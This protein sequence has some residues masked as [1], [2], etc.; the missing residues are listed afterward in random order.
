MATNQEGEDLMTPEEAARFLRLWDQAW[1][2]TLRDVRKG[3]VKVRAPRL[4]EPLVVWPEDPEGLD[5][6]LP[7]VPVEAVEAVARNRARSALK[8]LTYQRGH[9]QRVKVG[10]G[11][12][13]RRADLEAFVAA[14]GTP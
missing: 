1:E 2:R 10:R 6:R 12:Y 7:L 9:I 8:H 13:Y 11:T 5:E 14:G 3:K 4:G